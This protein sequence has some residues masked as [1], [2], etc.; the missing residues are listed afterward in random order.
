MLEVVQ[1]DHGEGYRLKLSFS[2]GERGV[3]DLA[4][5]LWGPVS[6]RCAT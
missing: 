2:S 1:A 4:D 6:R 5:A 3:V